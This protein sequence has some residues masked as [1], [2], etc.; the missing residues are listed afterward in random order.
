M[1][2]SARLLRGGRGRN[3]LFLV[4]FSSRDLSWPHSAPPQPKGHSRA[5]AASRLTAGQAR[6]GRAVRDTEWMRV[7][8]PRAIGGAEGPPVNAARLPIGVVLPRPLLGGLP[9]APHIRSGSVCMVVAPRGRQM[10]S[11]PADSPLCIRALR[12]PAREGLDEAGRGRGAYPSPGSPSPRGR[13][14]TLPLG[15][16]ERPHIAPATRARGPEKRKRAEAG[17][18]GAMW[19]GRPDYDC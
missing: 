10:R 14:A 3:I 9:S 6:L 7:E 8:G 18:T 5:T 13:K 2:D 12:Q 15:P 4:C 16:G 11:P 1:R 17:E 19:F